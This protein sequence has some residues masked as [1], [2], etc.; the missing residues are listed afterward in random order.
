MLENDFSLEIENVQVFY[1]YSC[2]TMSKTRK[3]IFSKHNIFCLAVYIP[4]FTIT[5]EFIAK[6]SFFGYRNVKKKFQ[7]E[8]LI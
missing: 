2:L 4:I 6:E 1:S 7:N 3:K 8:E 5:Q